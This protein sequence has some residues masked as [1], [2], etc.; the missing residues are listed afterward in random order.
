MASVWFLPVWQAL[1]LLALLLGLVLSAVLLDAG[2]GTASLSGK[3]PAGTTA[4]HTL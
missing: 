2:G 4:A 3:F 1:G